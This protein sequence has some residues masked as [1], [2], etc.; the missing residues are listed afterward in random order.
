V[1]LPI[2]SPLLGLLMLSVP[3]NGVLVPFN[4]CVGALR[5]FCAPAWIGNDVAV[6]DVGPSG[7]S[8]F[9]RYRARNFAICT[10]NQ[11][12]KGAYEASP[13][14]FLLVVDEERGKFAIPP[15]R[16]SRIAFEHED[17]ENLGDIFV[18]EFADARGERDLRPYFL[19]VDLYE[20]LGSVPP[21]QIKAIFAIGFPTEA[22]ESQATFDDEDMP[23]GFNLTVR[24]VRF[25]LEMAEAAPLDPENRRPLVRHRTFGQGL[26]NPDGL[27]GAPVFFVYIDEGRNAHLGFAGMITHSNGV[28]FALYEAETI[29]RVL[30]RYIDDDARAE[31]SPLP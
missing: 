22:R 7:S 27:S 12:G 17:H 25:Y 8:M 20:S 19:E 16:V 28:R 23:V 5:R 21:D 4:R 10:R 14:R 6:Y 11:F 15:N 30:D 13:D 1:A 24:W 31:S 3:I 18:G 2:A 9:I 29:R 26:T